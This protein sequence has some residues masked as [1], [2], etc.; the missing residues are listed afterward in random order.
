MIDRIPA[1]RV[2]LDAL[3]RQMRATF[4]ADAADAL[5]AVAELKEALGQ[6]RALAAIGAL[7]EIVQRSFLRVLADEMEATTPDPE[8]HYEFPA[9]LSPKMPMTRDKDGIMTLAIAFEVSASRDVAADR[10]REPLRLGLAGPTY[11][12]V[13]V[14]PIA[15]QP[16]LPDMT[17]DVEP[18]PPAPPDGQIPL[19]E[20]LAGMGGQETPADERQPEGGPSDASGDGVQDADSSDAGVDA[21]ADVDVDIDGEGAS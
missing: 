6:E 14:Q 2:N 1:P 12:R 13:V 16:R 19:E 10:F 9:H 7:W 15:R 11:C 18:E 21:T 3:A 17:V 4:D 8:Q 20:L 5:E